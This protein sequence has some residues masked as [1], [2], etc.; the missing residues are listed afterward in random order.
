VPGA[1]TKVPS[2]RQIGSSLWSAMT[3]MTA[4]RPS[5][6]DSAAPVI[7]LGRRTIDALAV[8]VGAVLTVA[9][10]VAGSLLLWGSRFAANY[11]DDELSSQNIVFPP[12]EALEEDGRADLAGY[13]GERVNTGG[14]AE[15][16]ASFIDGHLQDVADGATYADLGTPEREARAAVT[17]ARE[18]GASEDEIAALDETATGITRQRDTLFRGET[19]RGLLLSAYAWATVGQIAGYAAIGAF[20]AAVVLF[21]LVMLGVRHLRRLSPIS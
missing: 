9:L 5:A 6:P 4:T 20:V 14:E 10:V 8:A 7:P 17:A 21:V 12:A 13:G 2:A 11:V 3:T 16:Y 19:L 18:S 15:A 1:A